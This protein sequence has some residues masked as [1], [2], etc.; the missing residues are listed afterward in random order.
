M[1]GYIRPAAQRLSEEETERFRAVYCGLCHALGR[2]Y[3]F[4]AR[5]L[6]N[7]DFT[8]LAILLSLS[9]K[10]VC[11]R[12][13]CA[14]H[15]CKGC[16]AMRGTAALDTAA[17]HSVVLAWWQIQDHIAD[18][19]FFPGLK[20]RLAALILHR[21]YRRARAFVPAFDA[22]VQERLRELG[23]LERAGCASLDAAAEPFAA[24]LA[25][26]AEVE[27]DEKR[28]RIL[29]QIFYHLGRWI[30]L[31]DA[32]D[33]FK[34]DAK[35]GNYNPL[36]CRYHAEGDELSAT[37]RQALG[38]TLDASIRRMADAYALLDAGVWTPILDSIFYESFYAIGKA[39][40]DG[41]YHKPPRMGKSFGNMSE[42]TA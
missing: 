32:A 39:V 27:T 23:G 30:Y 1:F 33:D 36:R 14:A 12:R 9:A 35:S 38:E 16:A 37:D 29:R 7:Y 42:E 5:F 40:L 24:I 11:E 19:R 28:K 18:H 34:Q 13:R 17:D 21:A 22:A 15:P 3:G 25:E 26:I 2:R 6:L 10:P 20:Y 41:V 4:A 31:I 8:L